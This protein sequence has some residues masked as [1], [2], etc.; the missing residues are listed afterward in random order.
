MDTTMEVSDDFLANI[1]KLRESL[2]QQSVFKEP[3]ESKVDLSGLDED[4]NAFGSIV[5]RPACEASNLEAEHKR[6]MNLPDKKNVHGEFIVDV[7]ELVKIDDMITKYNKL[8]KELKTKKE[9][10]RK[11]TIDHMVKHKLEEARMG[12]SGKYSLT[13]RNITINPTTKKRLPDKLKDYFMKEENLDEI[14]S[15][16]RAERI[17]KWLYDNAE[18]KIAYS[19]R[20]YK[21]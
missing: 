17:F 1:V 15:A 14:K 4:D 6:L 18:K 8:I 21:K 16:E 10:L 7:K 11:K 19:L 3:G 20:R 13:Q 5:S 9:N 12:Q 2:Q